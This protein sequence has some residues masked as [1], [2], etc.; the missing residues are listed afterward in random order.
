MLYQTPSYAKTELQLPRTISAVYKHDDTLEFPEDKHH[1][2]TELLLQFM[3]DAKV[4]YRLNFDTLE[5]NLI[6]AG[7]TL[8]SYKHN[9]WRREVNRLEDRYNYYLRLVK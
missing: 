7:Y 3:A 4:R 1:I 2:D 9:N 5:S 8:K 6:A